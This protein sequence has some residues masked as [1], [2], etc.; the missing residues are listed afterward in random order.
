MRDLRSHLDR[1]RSV[2]VLRE[3]RALRGFTR[4][5]DDELKLTTGKALL[6][7]RPLPPDQD[8]LPA[9]VVKGEGH[10]LRARPRTPCSMG[11]TRPRSS[12]GPEDHRPLRRMSR[13]SV[14][15]HARTLSPRSSC[16]TRSRTCS[17]TSWSSP[18]ATAP[19]AS[20]APLRLASG[21]REMAG[22]LIYTAAGD[23]E[24]TMGGLVRMARPDNLRS[25]FASALRTPA[26]APR[27]RS[28]WTRGEGPRARLLQPCGLPRLRAAAGDEL[29]RV[30]PLPRPRPGDRYVRR[31]NAG[32]LFRSRSLGGS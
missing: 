10:L 18:A 21:G 6:R 13:R 31:S 23:S 17:S 9:Y 25:V 27:T 15:L 4:V 29:R 24:G 16:C 32:L 2:E 20:R 12:A 22:L 7:R 28:A 30:Q 14:A 11:G 8:W 26:G 19:L 5:R 3:T 1:V